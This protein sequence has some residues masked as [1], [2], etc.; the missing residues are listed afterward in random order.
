MYVMI[1]GNWSNCVGTDYCHY[2]G[3]YDSL[4]QAQED[5][6]T[7]AWETWEP[8]EDDDSGIEDEGP[9]YWLEEYNSDVHD[10][11]KAGGGSWPFE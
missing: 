1:R 11:L 8:Q 2:L 9:D 5:G 6:R 7:A 10:M 4:E 3:E